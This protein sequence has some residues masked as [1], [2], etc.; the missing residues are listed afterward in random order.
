MPDPWGGTFLIEGGR[1]T[2]SLRNL[3]FNQ[4]MLD[5]FAAVGAIGA[6]GRLVGEEMAV[7]APPV[8]VQ[9]FTFTSR[10]LF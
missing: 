2:R 5:A 4:S 8:L 10:T 6:E 1:I 3:R 9:E 7:H